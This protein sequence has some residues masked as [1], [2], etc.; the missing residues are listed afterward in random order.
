[1]KSS[2]NARTSRTGTGRQSSR[3]AGHPRSRAA[4]SAPA[5][6][7][8][9]RD[10]AL[11]LA[12]TRA[13]FISHASHEIRTPLHGIVG[14]STLL[15]GTE[16]TEE[17]RSFA[18]ALR[19]GVESLLSVVSDVLDVSRLDAGAMALERTGFDLTALVRGVTRSFAPT[20]HS[21]RLTLA[22]DT[23]AVKH[24]SLLGDPGRIRQVLVNLVDNAVK[25]TDVGSVVVRAETSFKRQGRIAV[26]ISVTDTGPGIVASSQRRLFQPFARLGPTGAGSKPGTGLGLVISKQLVEL[27]GGTLQVDSVPRCG[28]T[29]SF[30]L[31]LPQDL[32][33]AAQRQPEH[34]D[35]GSLRVYAADDDARSRRDLL[36]SL[37]SA[38]IGV[39]GSGTATSL[40]EALQSA[41]AAEALPDLVI[42]G[43][44][45]GADGDLAIARAVKTD[46]RLV[47][48]K[49]VL[50]PVAGVRGRAREARDAG[51][52]GYVSRPFGHAE[53]LRCTR[54]VAAR[55]ISADVDEHKELVTR[56]TVAAVPAP[57]TRRV[58]I[59]DDDASNRN[60]TRLQVERLGFAVDT[61]ESGKEAI[62]AAARCQYD[63]ILM[64]CQ[65]ADT[66]GLAA[67][68]AIR[69][70]ERHG[71]RPAILAMTADVS[72]RQR[73]RCRR[74]GMDDFLEKPVRT[75]LLAS[76]LDRYA[77]RTNGATTA[78]RESS[79]HSPVNESAVDALETDIG[80]ELT[81]DLVREYLDGAE[82]TID[83]LERETLDAPA[84]SSHAHRLLGGARILG[85]APLERLWETLADREEGGRAAV[86]PATIEDLRRACA[87]LRAW[88][89]VHEGSQHV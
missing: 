82:Q 22:T 19:V 14:Y 34:V 6:L 87:E 59:A 10:R 3:G 88:V 7:R 67:A 43:H 32:R 63:V 31:C 64:D 33:P 46:P 68:A 20:A 70:Q 57:V 56:H 86:P 38:G 29:F 40:P 80:S 21:R 45:D 27:M 76:V 47:D 16:L 11:E 12:R 89:Q 5:A 81:I 62:A 83:L 35:A 78:G 26:R 77:P 42:V 24:S 25:F 72:A 60:V 9:E 18:N 36:L 61:A 44:V 23:D 58:L 2:R 13:E 55:A 28:S 4:G 17:Q 53:L 75:Q 51:Y 49:L 41:L 1:M 65:M 8:A 39:S 84:A 85:L 50:A 71:H 73:E 54:A 69:R 74:A 30:E 79:E 15:L 37:A 66:D 52:D 48:V